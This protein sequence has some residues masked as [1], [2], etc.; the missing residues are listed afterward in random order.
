[1][2]VFVN[3]HKIVAWRNAFPVL[4]NVQNDGVLEVRTN[5]FGHA[6]LKYSFSQM[7]EDLDYNKS[8]N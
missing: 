2:A 3:P 6:R 5:V 7:E 8:L 4:G 1:M